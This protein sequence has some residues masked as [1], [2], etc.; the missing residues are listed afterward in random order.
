ML[1][2]GPVNLQSRWTCPSTV[3]LKI[4]NFRRLSSVS[5]VVATPSRCMVVIV[6]PP[7]DQLCSR[8]ISRRTTVERDLKRLLYN[9]A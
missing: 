7:H 9:A 6:M 5:T 1:V 2:V 3:D 4:L 8:A